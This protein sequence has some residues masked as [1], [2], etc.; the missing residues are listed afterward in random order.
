MSCH[1]LL[2]GICLTQGSNP[3]LL[4]RQADSLPLSSRGS[5]L[6]FLIMCFLYFFRYFSL[7]YKKHWNELS[8]TVKCLPAVRETRVQSLGWEDPLEKEMATHSST[9]VWKIPRTKEPGRL[10]SMGSQRVGHDWATSHTYITESGNPKMAFRYLFF[11]KLCFSKW[12]PR[13]FLLPQTSF[14]LVLTNTC[15]AS[16][17][18]VLLY[19]QFNRKPQRR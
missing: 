14:A 8:S 12:A 9:I 4:H 13:S 19:L 10:Q 1:F 16:T 5:P 3:C 15:Q 2:H 6:M 7:F 11:G 17:D 18:W